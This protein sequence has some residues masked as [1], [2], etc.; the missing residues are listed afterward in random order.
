MLVPILWLRDYTDVNIDIEEY[1]ERMV[2]SGSNIET[3][4]KYGINTEKVFVGRIDKIKPHP[5][6][7]RLVICDVNIGTE[8]VQIVTGAS[9][10][11]EGAFVPVAVDG[12]KIPGPLHGQSKDGDSVVIMKGELR[13]INSDGMLCGATELG[14]D[15][16]V[17]PIS[18]KNGIW[19]LDGEFMPG[20]PFIDAMELLQ[21]VVDF[22]IT[23]NRPDCLSIIGMARETAATIGG[24]LKYPAADCKNEVEDVKEYI[25]VEVKNPA[26][27]KRYIARVVKDVKVAQSPWWM[28]K[29]LIMAGVRPIN[30]IVD[31]TNYV[32][33][34]YGQPLHAF[35][36]RQIKGNK[37]TVDTAGQDENFVTLDEKKR[38]LDDSMLMIKDAEKSIGI[39]GVMGGLNSEIV[40][41]TSIIVI[42][43]AN[44]N[45]DNIRE[46]SKKL[47]LRT[48]AAARFEKGID[49]NLAEA[50][51]DRVCHLIELLDAGTVIKG[52]I[53][54]YPDIYK[55]REIA[56]RVS[57]INKVLGIELSANEIK[58]LLESLE[59]S[60]GI[61]GDI[62]EI[63]SPTVRQD[64]VEE[65]DFI[66]EVARMY[67]YDKIPNKL[68]KGNSESGMTYTRKLRDICRESMLSMGLNEV[69][70][71]S[72][73]SP[74]DLE[75]TGLNDDINYNAVVKL[76]NPL[77]EDT[78]VMRTTLMPMLLSVIARNV[79][80]KVADV[81][82]FEIGNTFIPETGDRLPVETEK[83]AIGLYGEGM[84]FFYLKGLISALLEKL[85]TSEAKY[86]AGKLGVF[87]PGRNAE[88]FFDIEGRSE[89]IGVIGEV[90]PKVA[91]KY[92]IVGRVYMAELE[93]TRIIK[94]ADLVKVYEPLPRY[95]SIT[96]DIALIVKDDCPVGELAATIREAGG[97]LL[98]SAKMFDIYRGTQLKDSEKSVAYALEYRA[99]N[100]TLTESE[101][102]EVHEHVLEMLKKNHNAIP[103]ES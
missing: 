1:C 24:K 86:L 102:E 15:D 9:N 93:L 57:R 83:I 80:R 99:K 12:A 50:A 77:G 72:F 47:K 41:D 32:M 98:E 2:M 4:E 33:L 8:N 71:Y 87:H 7:D 73:V 61:K 62:L 37:I 31:I 28:Q 5:N 74:H 59:M 17:V 75:K 60:V 88:L 42:E 49:P 91:E 16:S 96:R 21:D 14:L 85:G 65:V 70:T 44:F 30:N 81:K 90:H 66:E 63:I 64:L 101:V 78:S 100:R 29:R 94:Y 55:P 76:I 92:G 20:T 95:P 3:V 56:A 45:G 48:E 89:Q 97:E 46:T 52:K 43:S 103:R 10:V 26:L 40:E 53:D 79:S 19:I 68:A 38:K 69:Q 27:C 54:V 23:P 51:A 6:A 34:E 13:G 35:D 67:G 82:A 18:H 22:E 36:I 11:F 84:D 25:D 39:A 58:D